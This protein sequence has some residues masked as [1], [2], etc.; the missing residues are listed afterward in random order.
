MPFPKYRERLLLKLTLPVLKGKIKHVNEAL[1]G[2]SIIQH[3]QDYGYRA[4]HPEDEHNL[5]LDRENRRGHLLRLGRADEIPKN[6]QFSGSFLPG[7]LSDQILS[8]CKK[9]LMGCLNN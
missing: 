9:N 2:V 4:A 1:R 8:V 3:S 5:V 6:G 7:F